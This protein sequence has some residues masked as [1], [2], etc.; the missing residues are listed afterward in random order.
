MLP[1]KCLQSG[2][3]ANVL[4]VSRS[5]FMLANAALFPVMKTEVLYTANPAL[6]FPR[7]LSSNSKRN[8]AV[9][10]GDDIPYHFNQMASQK[11][12][13]APLLNNHVVGRPT[14]NARSRLILWAHGDPGLACPHLPH[15]GAANISPVGGK[16]DLVLTKIAREAS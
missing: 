2:F 16:P 4:F 15:L 8:G 13:L 6:T 11:S 5:A 1:S 9:Y 3:L 12:Y 7:F 10:G 14:S